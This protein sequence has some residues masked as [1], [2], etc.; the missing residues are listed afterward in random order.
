MV[1]ETA[2]TA[3][4][5][6]TDDPVTYIHKVKE[7]DPA[8]RNRLILQGTFQ[9][10]A[11]EI[12]SKQFPKSKCGSHDRCFNESWYQTTVGK[13]TFERKWL[14]YSPTK[15]AVF[16]HFSIFFCGKNKETTFTK[17]GYCDWRKADEKL[18]KHEQSQC[19]INTTVDFTHFCSR[20]AINEQ[21]S[22]EAT[23]M[24]T[25]RQE[26]VRKNKEIIKR[27]IDITLCLAQQGIL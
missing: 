17:T 16:C 6:D 20:T 13:N 4:E 12:T 23:R 21:L 25:A 3:Y 5:T 2:N 15:D 9:P 19:H 27:L 14:S 10:K 1:N 8:L 24:E 7:L 18:V 22:K 26:K 11:N